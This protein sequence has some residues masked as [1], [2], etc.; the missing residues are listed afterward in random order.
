[1]RRYDDA[2][3]AY[4]RFLAHAPEEVERTR[5][6]GHALHSLGRHAEAR[7]HYDAVLARPAEEGLAGDA[8]AFAL[9]GRGLALHRLG[10]L[11]LARESLLAA[12]TLEPQDPKVHLALAQVDEERGALDEA[13]AS[14]Q[15]ARAL[16]PFDPSAAFI[17][18]TLLAEV[19]QAESAAAAR[20]EFARLAPLGAE[21]DD[22]ELR[23]LHLPRD[24]SALAR[25][26]R[27]HAELGD[28]GGVARAVRRLDPST[29][30]GAA[31]TLELLYEADRATAEVAERRLMTE[32]ASDPSAWDALA[33]H[34]RRQGNA[35]QHEVALVRAATL[36]AGDAGDV[37]PTSRDR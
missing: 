13:L 35:T 28:T 22:L 17:L 8:R 30:L 37:A 34:Y 21:I 12:R 7:A 14:A 27:C 5:H 18:A 3:E 4:R 36:R 10:E 16:A 11:Q 24:R 15:R 25:L 31:L 23:L 6:L 26:A 32:H 9:R 20:A 2:V 33:A 19:G 29:I 1:L